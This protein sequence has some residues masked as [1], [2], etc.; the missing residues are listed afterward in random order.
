LSRQARG[1][2]RP[3]LRV[4]IETASIGNALA[5]GPIIIN[6]HTGEARLGLSALPAEEQL[7][8]V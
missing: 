3:E 2:Q 1:T 5:G 6:R 4:Y 8:E 7:D